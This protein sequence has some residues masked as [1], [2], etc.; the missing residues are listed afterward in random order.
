MGNKDESKSLSVALIF[1]VI[2]SPLFLQA[3]SDL[4]K[5]TTGS[6]G[7]TDIVNTP[8]FELLLGVSKDVGV[9]LVPIVGVSSYEVCSR[10]SLH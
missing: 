2:V 9:A 6:D 7:K 3:K 4:Q 10:D 1:A 8:E 5:F